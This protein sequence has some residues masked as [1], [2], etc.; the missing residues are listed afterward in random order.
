M[1]IGHHRFGAVWIQR[2]VVPESSDCSS[3]AG[4]HGMGFF[5]M[6][7]S[8]WLQNG[9]SLSHICSYY[10]MLFDFF[11]ELLHLLNPSEGEK[12]DP[13]LYVLNLE[14][15]SCL[16]F[17]PHP[18]AGRSLSLLA[19]AVYSCPSVRGRRWLLPAASAV[20]LGWVIL[21]LCS[22]P[23]WQLHPY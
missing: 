8:S 4:L 16:R 22:L 2:A 5:W 15:S 19:P 6:C 3:L 9:E 11:L 23:G 7:G 17:S 18:T 10:R 20:A 21:A 14:S 13:N 1:N 12:W